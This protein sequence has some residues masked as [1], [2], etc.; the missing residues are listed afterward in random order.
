MYI[1]DKTNKPYSRS[2]DRSYDYHELIREAK[3][4]P[5]PHARALA[6]KGAE[7]IRLESKNIRDMRQALIKAHRKQ[8]KEEIKDIHDIVAHKKKYSHE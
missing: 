5:D 8:D 7:Q 6:A 1:I 4:N 2:N 3:N